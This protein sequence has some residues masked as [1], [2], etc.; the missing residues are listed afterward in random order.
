MFLSVVAGGAHMFEGHP[1]KEDF[2]SFLRGAPLPRARART[3]QILRHLL[4]DCTV[5]RNDLTHMGWSK[6]RL[7]RLV[8]PSKDAALGEASG[9][10]YDYSTAFAAAE[11]SVTAFLAAEPS[12]EEVSAPLLFQELEAVEADERLQ[13]VSAGGPFATPAMVRLLVD[14]SHSLRYKDAA[15]MLHFAHLARLAAEGCSAAQAG[16][17]MRLADLRARAWNQLG[18]ALRVSNRPREAEE[19]LISAGE[20]RERGTGDPLLRASVLERVSSLLVF[21]GRFN[22]AIEMYEE[23]GQ[24][25]EEL[26]LTARLAGIMIYKAMAYIYSGETERALAILNQSIPLINHEEDPHLLFAACHNLIWCYVDLDRPD[27]ALMLYNE[28]RELYQEF[29]DPLILLRATWQ[30]GRLLR[31]LGHLRAAETTLLRSRKGFI[32][33]ELIHEVALVSL[34]LAAVYVK[35]GL[36]EEVKRTVLM[37]LPVFHALRVKLETLAALLQLQQVADQEQQALALIRTL[38]SGIE[39]LPKK[40]TH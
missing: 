1:S 14:R 13:R 16:G 9:G 39:A 15:E 38:N 31:D 19:A 11:R 20:H 12:E 40:S 28:V 5:C 21:Q 33:K 30:E 34:D 29:D 10:G 27:Q 37:T 35:L 23:A 4:S 26:E 32:E 8:H 17:E 7:T 6:E 24:V 22:E 18:S 3:A 2:A 36:V 25:Y